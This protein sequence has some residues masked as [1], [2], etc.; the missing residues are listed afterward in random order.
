[1]L[2]SLKSAFVRLFCVHEW[3]LTYVDR[4]TLAPKERKCKL[5]GQEQLA[6]TVWV[7]K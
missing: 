4:I 7:N 3:E 5:C 2:S 6:T 1:M